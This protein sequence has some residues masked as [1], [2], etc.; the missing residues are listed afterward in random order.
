MLRTYPS[1]GA[2]YNTSPS[3]FISGVWS[4]IP[5]YT[6]VL[7]SLSLIFSSLPPGENQEIGRPGYKSFENLGGLNPSNTFPCQSDKETVNLTFILPSDWEKYWYIIHLHFYFEINNKKDHILVDA[8]VNGLGCV[9]AEFFPFTDNGILK[10]RV[11]YFNMIQGRQEFITENN[12]ALIYI[13]NYIPKGGKLPGE[14]TKP[15][16]VEGLKTG[17]NMLNISLTGAEGVTNLTIFENLSGIECTDIAPPDIEIDKPVISG[18]MKPGKTFTVTTRVWNKGDFP[19]K[20]VTVFIQYPS[21]KLTL[22]EN[23]TEIIHEIENE[24]W[25]SWRFM[26][27]SEGNCKLAIIA[28]ASND[29]VA[30]VEGN[31]PVYHDS[32]MLLHSIGA[33]II[34]GIILAYVLAK[35]AP[36]K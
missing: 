36:F 8:D 14:T 15:L 26:A 18:E 27:R 22:L 4:K 5:K 16:L 29:G 7:V 6:A 3:F 31:V 9:F 30:R 25:V 2:S 12:S 28:V 21:D 24:A 32:G 33:I 11:K 17:R 34:I 13:A 10:M 19:L 1:E 23:D 35:K 20:D